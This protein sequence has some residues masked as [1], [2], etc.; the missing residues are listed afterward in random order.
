[1]HDIEAGLGAVHRL[2]HVDRAFDDV[3][4]VRRDA[5]GEPR[6]DPCPEPFDRPL[7]EAVKHCDAVGGEVA[8]DGADRGAGALGDHLRGQAFEP[9]LVDDLGRRVEQRVETL[10]AATLG[11]LGAD[12][13]L[14]R[15]F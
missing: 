10:G 9:D 5:L 1:M 8:I 14:L 4:P 2:G 3:P 12:G 13:T 15:V 11:R 7:T 6:G